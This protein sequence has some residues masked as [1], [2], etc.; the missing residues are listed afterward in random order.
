SGRQPFHQFHL[1][2]ADRGVEKLDLARIVARL[3]QAHFELK[4]DPI[5]LAPGRLGLLVGIL[6]DHVP[7]TNRLSDRMKSSGGRAACSAK[8]AASLRFRERNRHKRTW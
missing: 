6:I 4:L 5:V 2:A 1:A 3:A 7:L 8:R